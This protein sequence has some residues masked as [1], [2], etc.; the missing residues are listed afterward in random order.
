MKKSAFNLTHERRGTYRPDGTLYPILC[1]RLAPGDVFK[2]STEI[3]GRMIPLVGP[4]MQRF[5]MFIHYYAV[6]D[7]IIWDNFTKF[8]SPEFI[9]QIPP[10]PPVYPSF[11]VRALNKIN[12]ASDTV[13]INQLGVGSLADHFGLQFQPGFEPADDDDTG[14]LKFSSMPFRA[15][16]EIWN[17]HY[18]DVDL[19]QP[20]VVKHSDGF[21]WDDEQAQ[22]S[23]L[24]RNWEKDYF[25]AARPYAQKGAPVIAPLGDNTL[26]ENVDGIIPRPVLRSPNGLVIS[27]V[28][29]LQA[30]A[31]T[32]ELRVSD[33]SG[34]VIDPNGSL[35]V[36]G[37][38]SIA[39]L[40][41]A[42]AYQKWTEKLYR[43]GSRYKEFLRGVFGVRSSDARLD[44]PEYIGGGRQPFS[45]GEVLQTAQSEEAPLGTYGGHGITSGNHSFF[46]RAEEDCQVIGLLSIMPRSSYLTSVNRQFVID[47]MYDYIIPDFAG[48][49]N[50]EIKNFELGGH[51]GTG[52]DYAGTWGYTDR[53][54]QYKFIPSTNHGLFRTDTN[55]LNYHSSRIIEGG[56]DNPL[57]DEFIQV[58]GADNVDRVF[59]FGMYG[60]DGTDPIICNIINRCTGIRSLPRKSMPG[61]Y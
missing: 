11:K 25:T 29:S 20:L 22:F 21:V 55:L 51:F 9:G 41:W 43:T 16:R 50:Q 28:T 6:P 42:N 30:A 59:A 17:Y 35:E 36:N 24:K 23:F 31:T 3:F 12:P 39:E 45:I 37:G 47:D 44:Y 4:V 54:A 14:S 34:A 19:Q 49:G 7:R 2:G 18:R 52:H 10:T 38:I 57:D 1:Q 56:E 33:G 40:R 13:P 15:Y 8:R 60:Q 27:G 5:D 48:I 58:T 53:Y 61:L 32:G 46:Y 26:V